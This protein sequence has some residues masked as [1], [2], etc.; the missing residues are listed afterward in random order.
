M[1]FRKDI[2]K[3]VAL[4]TTQ[5]KA[6]DAD[7]W[8]KLRRILQYIKCTIRLPLILSAD[9]LN[10]IKWWVESS[11]A[12]HDNMRGNTGETMYLGHGS[13]LSMS[14]RK[15]LN[16][17]SSTEAE[18]IGADDALPQMLW[19]KYLIEAQRYGIDKNIMYRDSLS[20][21]LLET[22]GKKSSTKKKKHIKVRYF[23]IKDWVA[24]GDVELKHCS[25]T[26]MLV[27]HFI[28]PLKG[29]LFR[30]FRAEFMSI[31]EDADITDM[32]WDRTKIEK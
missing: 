2:Q 13:V 14:K 11:Y 29:E 6:P 9:N 31:I 1:R 10:I 24:T 30:R 27:D 7:E 16:M 19:T 21:M 17:K 8:K 5:V 28:K 32:G 25:T 26:K 3:S 4:L 18:L 15:K 23:F 20:S 12:A 22:N